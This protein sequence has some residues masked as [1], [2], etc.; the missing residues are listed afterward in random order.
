MR[1]GR[2]RRLKFMTC[3][4]P[5]GPGGWCC[6]LR[7]ARTQWAEIPLPSSPGAGVEGR[8]E[9]CG[10]I[11]MAKEETRAADPAWIGVPTCVQIGLCVLGPDNKP[12]SS[13]T[14]VTSFTDMSPEHSFKGL[15]S[16]GSDDTAFPLL[17]PLCPGCAFPLPSLSTGP[18]ADPSPAL[19]LPMVAPS[20]DMRVI[21][22][23][24][25]WGSR[26]LRT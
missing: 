3:P 8:L 4:E 5:S 17:P 7:S 10:R 19:E 20:T 26:S 16:Y 21:I 12:H 1:A 22:L 13:P 2:C 24:G 6:W 18:V 11:V 23:P 14:S 25:E 15:I 9:L